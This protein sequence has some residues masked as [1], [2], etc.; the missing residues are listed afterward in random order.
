MQRILQQHAI[1]FL[2]CSYRQIARRTHEGS[3]HDLLIGRNIVVIQLPAY[4]MTAMNLHTSMQ[5]RNGYLRI[6]LLLLLA[7]ILQCLP[8]RFNCSAQTGS[9]AGDSVAFVWKRHPGNPVFPAEPG[10]WR[11]SQTANPDLLL[12][13]DVYYMYF[14][15]QSKGHDRIGVATIPRDKFDGV[16]WNIDLNR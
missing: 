13:D 16:T 12:K 8:F 5:E 15:G 2:L 3:L 14:R 4:E 9:D 10:T 6:G 7:S 1:F 11:E